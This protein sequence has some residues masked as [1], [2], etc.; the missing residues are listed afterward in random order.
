MIPRSR[1]LRQ[2]VQH[3]PQ[4]MHPASLLPGF[5]PHVADRATGP[6]RRRRWPGPALAGRGASGPAGRSTSS[7]RSPVPVLDRDQL[8]SPV[9]AHTQQDQRAQ[10]IVL[11]TDPEVHARPP[12]RTRSPR[13]V[14]S[15]EGP[16]LL[17][18]GRRHPR[19]AGSRH[20]RGLVPQQ[21]IESFPEIARRKAPYVQH[22]KHLR[23]LRR[24]THV[25]RKDRTG[26][27]MIRPPIMHA[28]SLHFR[29]ASAGRL[30]P[31][32]ASAVAHH[33]GPTVGAALGAV[34]LHV[35]GDF[36]V[37]SLHQHPASALAG[38]LIQRRG[39][40]PLR[41]GSSI[42][43]IGRRVLSPGIR[44]GIQLNTQEDTP[45]DLHQRI[46]NFWQ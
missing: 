41:D 30:S 6:E 37:Q 35:V 8:L 2:L 19:D 29:R 26:E 44:P 24:P 17:L 15:P 18:P 36:G 40:I 25:R 10:A 45:P 11:Q 39:D 32:P 5:G 14:P 33:Q 27:A 3:V 1:S 31:R 21:G 16:V 22:R 46:H 28:R 20:A 9:T 4:S 13:Q 23:H 34:S 12:T 38:Q 42:L 43:S 7:P